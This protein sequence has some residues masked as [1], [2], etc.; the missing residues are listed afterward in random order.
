MDD[1]PDT[2][3]YGSAD[4]PQ[5]LFGL[6]LLDDFFVRTNTEIELSRFML[7]EDGCNRLHPFPKLRKSTS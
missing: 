7:V 5:R 2:V 1:R 4:L 6:F 3:A